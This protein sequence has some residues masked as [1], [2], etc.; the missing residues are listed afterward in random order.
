[1]P[2]DYYATL[3]VVKDASD[4]DLK[5]GM[6]SVRV[7]G[8]VRVKSRL[9]AG[10]LRHGQKTPRCCRRSAHLLPSLSLLPPCP[11]NQPTASWP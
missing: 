8:T 11:S 3:G 4:A 7:C 10:R 5:K 2:A 9:V 1:M 6:S